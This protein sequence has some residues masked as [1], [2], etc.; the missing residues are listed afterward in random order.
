MDGSIKRILYIYTMGYY[1]G[2]IKNEFL[3]HMQ[4]TSHKMLDWMNHMLESRLPGAISTTSDMQMTP[5]LRH[6]AKRN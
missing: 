5:P 1:S 2:L 3:T 6:K 4:S